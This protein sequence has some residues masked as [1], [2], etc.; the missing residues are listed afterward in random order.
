MT[1]LQSLIKALTKIKETST[2]ILWLSPLREKST[3]QKI[4]STFFLASIFILTAVMLNLNLMTGAY[5]I[6]PLLLSAYCAFKIIDS[7]YLVA[8][9]DPQGKVDP[10]RDNRAAS[11][12]DVHR[13]NVPSHPL[14][15]QG[16]FS[17]QPQDRASVNS[18]VLYSR[19]GLSIIP[20][21]EDDR[22]PIELALLR[23]EEKKPFEYLAC[24][25]PISLKTQW[26]QSKG[27]IDQTL[28]DMD[29]VLDFMSRQNDHWRTTLAE[30]EELTNSQGWTKEG[31]EWWT[32]TTTI[33]HLKE[34][35]TRI[36]EDKTRIDDNIQR[37]LPIKYTQPN[38]NRLYT[39]LNQQ[40]RG[41]TT[42]Y[43]QSPPLQIPTSGGA[44]PSTSDQSLR[45]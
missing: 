16:D 27:L 2:Q 8:T 11:S 39:S 31:L 22:S 6:I 3:N 45:Y 4:F 43:Y 20:E 35:L 12:V 17:P 9:Q 18:E 21:E 28:Q 36:C 26:E 37:E 34:G 32:N 44:Q 41:I 23:L 13:P 15:S 5:F 1:G 19:Q 42:L 24:D 30:K 7:I 33:K 10:P 40:H 25:D 38:V 29:T 14:G